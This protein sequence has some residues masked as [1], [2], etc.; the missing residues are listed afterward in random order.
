VRRTW[1]AGPL[2]AVLLAATAC[3][4]GGDGD[5]A[6]EQEDT[7]P[8]EEATTSTTPDLDAQLAAV[9]VAFDDT[10]AHR[11]TIHSLAFDADLPESTGYL[12]VAQLIA[13]GFD[14]E[15]G[16][17]GAE[18]TSY[19]LQAGVDPQPASAAARVVDGIL[20]ESTAEGWLGYDL[21]RVT[22]GAVPTSLV[23]V[24][25]D[26]LLAAVRDATTE[27]LEHDSLAGGVDVWRVLATLSS[28]VPQELTI[29]TRSDG[30]VRT[31]TSTNTV[32]GAEAMATVPALVGVL[33]DLDEV[34]A[35]L[36]VSIDAAGDRPLPSP[37]EPPCAAP[38]PADGPNGLTLRCPA[39]A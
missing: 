2:A 17:G 15:T 11:T 8:V 26:N 7:T 13:G 37:V 31:I 30:T 32:T 21:D 9:R 5:A 29:R 23:F 3:S 34:T 6:D 16:D 4:G 24:A 20:W 36:E 14:E 35:T 33:G 18:G 22:G 12:S 38:E 1:A 28:G 19:L 25:I 39:E 10:I 27:V